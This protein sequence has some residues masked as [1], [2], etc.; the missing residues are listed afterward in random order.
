M[1]VSSSNPRCPL[2][3]E[4][5]EERAVPSTAQ[6]V[7]AVYTD[8]LHR[9]PSQAETASWVSALDS[10][11]T[12]TQMIQVVSTSPEF[13]RDIIIGDY[14][15][16]LHRTPSAG[17]VALWQ[18]ALQGGMSEDAIAAAFVASPEYVALHGSTPTAWLNSVYQ[19]VLG[20]PVDSVGLVVWLQKTDQAMQPRYGEIALGVLE[21]LEARADEVTLAYQALLNR[22]PD[23]SGLAAWEAALAQNPNPH[24]VLANIAASPEFINLVTG[25]TDLGQR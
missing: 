3:V 1:S 9:Q 2:R 16:F 23:A 18:N 4:A 5:L 7:T 15:Q 19:D 22:N 11:T 25:G 10:G 13:Q 21:S 20:R 6:Y 14:S 24:Q 8:L 17:E 12:P